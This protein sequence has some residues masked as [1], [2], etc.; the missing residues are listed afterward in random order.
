MWEDV[1]MCIFKGDS[2]KIHWAQIVKL[3]FSEREEWFGQQFPDL[4]HIESHWDVLE[5]TLQSGS[6]LPLSIQDLGQKLMHH[7]MEINVVIA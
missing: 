6:T 2:V 3:W 1:P 5:S 7:L 4:T